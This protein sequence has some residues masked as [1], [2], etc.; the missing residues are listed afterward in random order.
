[1]DGTRAWE[2]WSQKDEHRASQLVAYHRARG[3]SVRVQGDAIYN[4]LVTTRVPAATLAPLGLCCET[5]AHLTWVGDDV[6]RVFGL[7]VDGDDLQALLVGLADAWV[8]LD[9]WSA[10]GTR[11]LGRSRGA[12]RGHSLPG[13]RQELR[14][15][16][17]ERV[18]VACGRRRFLC[19]RGN[20]PIPAYLPS[21]KRN[22]NEYRFLPLLFA[23]LR[24]LPSLDVMATPQN[25]Q[26]IL[27]APPSP[28]SPLP[29]RGWEEGERKQKG[30]R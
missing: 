24:P 30:S 3:D 15:Q 21:G 9:L 1:M 14:F 5:E 27:W 4:D 10:T 13:A 16:R 23:S 8:L 28:A 22:M 26:T 11:T 19:L 20:P 25:S 2:W 29:S 12:P 7:L 17:T 6:S 18:D